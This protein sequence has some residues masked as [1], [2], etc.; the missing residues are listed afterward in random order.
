MKNQG[1]YC[2]KMIII[3]NAL[4]GKSKFLLRIS[5]N[6]WDEKYVPTVG[7]D[8]VRYILNLIRE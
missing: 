7:V 8:F 1:T 2:V 3:G 4:V 6:T 5:N